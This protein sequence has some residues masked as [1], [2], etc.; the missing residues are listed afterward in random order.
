[1]NIVFYGFALLFLTAAIARAISRAYMKKQYEPKLK[2][3]GES[4]F[5]FWQFIKKCPTNNYGRFA[6]FIGLINLSTMI[7]GPF[8]A[9]YMLIQLKFNYITFTLISLVISAVATLI[10]MPLWGRFL[11]KYG[12]VTTMR[13]TVW[14][15]PIIPLLW[16]VSPSPYWLVLVQI[17]SGVAWAGFNLSSGTFTYQAVTKE[18]MNLCVAYSSIFNGIAIFLGAT[19][20]G[21]LASLNIS[22]MNIFLFVFF[23]SGIIRMLVIILLFPLIREVRPVK[24]KPFLKLILRPLKDM[25][26][27]GG[28]FNLIHYHNKSKA[29]H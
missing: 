1:M 25:D 9:P 21:L 3:K 28:F 4:Y 10:T 8:F 18:R 17:I 7:A 23:V 20:G 14:A 19:I 22:F 12:C 15:I 16:L 6:I 26:F 13:V 2:I 29:K 24:S 27:M 11:D 5:S